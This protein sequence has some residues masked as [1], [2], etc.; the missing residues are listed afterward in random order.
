ME[1][2]LTNLL[3]NVDSSLSPPKPNTLNKG[4]L[5]TLYFTY[6]AEEMVYRGYTLMHCLKLT[7]KQYTEYAVFDSIGMKFCCVYKVMMM[8]NVS[9]FKCSCS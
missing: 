6:R 4:W 5:I 9:M 8:V 1:E 2:M 3:A 7:K